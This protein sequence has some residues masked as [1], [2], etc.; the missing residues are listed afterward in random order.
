MTVGRAATLLCI[1]AIAILSLLPAERL[2]RRTLGGHLEHVFAYLA[3]AS[4]AGMA[5]RERHLAQLLLALFAYAGSLEFLQRF[6]PGRSSSVEDFMFSAIGIALGVALSALL[7][8][9]FGA[10]HR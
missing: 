8:R 10:S 9:L 2:T 4:I 7:N 5:Y 3:T 1:L 6:S